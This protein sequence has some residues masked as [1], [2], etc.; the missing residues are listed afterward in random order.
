MRVFF[1]SLFQGGSYELVT[2][3][4]EPLV[5]HLVDQRIEQHDCN[6]NCLNASSYEQPIVTSTIEPRSGW[7]SA[8][9]HFLS[10]RVSLREANSRFR[11]KP[12][13]LRYK[14]LKGDVITLDDLLHNLHNCFTYPITSINTVLCQYSHISVR[15]QDM[16][17]SYFRRRTTSSGWLDVDCVQLFGDCLAITFWRS[18]LSAVET[19][20]MIAAFVCR[21]MG[22]VSESYDTLV[23]P[24]C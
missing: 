5:D 24:A 14:T 20:W 13:V 19:G 2:V 11:Q 8:S 9:Q 3:G 12:P 10:L 1:E 17:I 23:W 18:G 21:S 16:A 7:P 6:G 22:V 4:S 15:S